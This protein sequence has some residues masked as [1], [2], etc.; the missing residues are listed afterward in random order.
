MTVLMQTFWNRHSWQAFYRLASYLARMY[1]STT[2]IILTRKFLVNIVYVLVDRLAG[3]LARMGDSIQAKE[4]LG[5]HCICIYS[6]IWRYWGKCFDKEILRKHCV[7][8]GLYAC[9]LPGKEVWQYWGKRFDK[10]THGKH[11]TFLVDKLA[12]FLAR[13]Y[14]SIEANILTRKFFESIVY[15]LVYWLTSYLARMYG[16]IEANIL[17]K[18][19]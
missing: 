17:R 13:M 7:Y 19:F 15:I 18:K 14:G 10:E 8:S 4:N 6:G 5:K 12:G 3:F 2:A 9:K 11:C 1:D 16:S